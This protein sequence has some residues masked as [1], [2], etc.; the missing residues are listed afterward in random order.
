MVV[1]SGAITAPGTDITVTVDMTASTGA[2]SDYGSDRGT[3]T[4][5][6]ATLTKYVRNVS[7]ASGN[8]GGSGATSFSTNGTSYNYYTGGVTGEPNDILEYVL[9][10]RNTSG[11]RRISTVLSPISC[12]R[13]SSLSIP[14]PG[15]LHADVLYMDETGTENPLTDGSGDDQ[16]TLSGGTLTVNVGRHQDRPRRVPSGPAA[17]FASPTR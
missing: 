3:F 10:A 13:I 14:T 11:G 15:P 7:R 2:G 12:L 4:S 6:S 8:S 1:T 16:A 9:V 17:L 5:G